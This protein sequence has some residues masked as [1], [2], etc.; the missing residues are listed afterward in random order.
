MQTDNLRETRKQGGEAEE[1]HLAF[2]IGVTI[3]PAQ[4]FPEWTMRKAL[5]YPRFQPEGAVRRKV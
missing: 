1:I 4:S 2:V 3:A 5:G